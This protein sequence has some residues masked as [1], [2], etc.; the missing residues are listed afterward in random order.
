MTCCTY[1]NAAGALTVTRHGCAPAVPSF[2]ELT[3][4][5]LRDGIGARPDM[6]HAFARLHRASTRW[7]DWPEL[8]IMAFDHRI[9]F[10]DMADRVGAGHDRIP[11][12]KK[13]IAKAARQAGGD[14]SRAGVLVDGRWGEEALFEMTGNNQWIA[15]P[16]ELPA[17]RPLEFD[18]NIGR[19]IAAHLNSWP[20][21]Q[22]V[23]CLLFY[24]PDDEAGLKAQQEEKILQLYDACIAADKELLLE[25]IPPRGSDVDNRTIARAVARFYALGVYPDW[26]K[27][28]PAA[29]PEAWAEISAV[30]EANDRYCRGILLLGLEAPP[31]ELAKGFRAVADYPWVKGFAVGR[32]PF[33]AGPAEDWLAGTD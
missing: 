32:D 29:E 14:N 1:A 12:V 17:S 33:W 31:E 13:L 23:K 2:E 26:W 5:I 3:E 30:I 28:P 20:Q 18:H 22:V 24:H 6:D 9:Q 7:R 21:E 4:F 11:Q 8:E 25:I 27:L 16:V 15:R 10:E 19:N